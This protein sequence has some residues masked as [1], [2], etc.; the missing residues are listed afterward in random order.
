MTTTGGS[1][2]HVE[3]KGCIQ[4]SSYKTSVLYVPFIRNNPIYTCWKI[5]LQ[6]LVCL[7]FY[8]GRHSASICWPNSAN[9]PPCQFQFQIF[10][11]PNIRLHYSW[12]CNTIYPLKAKKALVAWEEITRPR[13]EGGLDITPFET[14]AQALKMTHVTQIIEGC[15]TEWVWIC[16]T[17]IWEALRIGP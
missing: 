2:L 12:W 7:M 14:Q 9:L 1:K 5:R 17:F 10:L 16:N 6:D 15:G 13:A 11:L 4:F 3:G 8:L